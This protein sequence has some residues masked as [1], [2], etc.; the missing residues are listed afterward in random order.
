MCGWGWNVQQER[1]D[2]SDSSMRSSSK[3]R[4]PWNDVNHNPGPVMVKAK[5]EKFRIPKIPKTKRPSSA[6]AQHSGLTTSLEFYILTKD[7][8]FKRLLLIFCVLICVLCCWGWSVSGRR[9]AV[10]VILRRGAVRNR[11]CL[12][13]T[14]ITT[15][16]K[17]RN[18]T[19][20]MAL[21]RPRDDGFYY[22][23]VLNK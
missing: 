3:S 9:A 4:L 11:D 18:L 6:Q 14:S 17:S 10:R 22:N 7:F 16:R 21:G 1:G 20:A 12:G 13:V 2:S 8:N 19:K 23:S 15:G 5:V